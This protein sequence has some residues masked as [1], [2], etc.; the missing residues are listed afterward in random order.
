M[1]ESQQLQKANM[2]LLSKEMSDKDRSIKTQLLLS[3]SKPTSEKLSGER[4]WKNNGFF[5]DVRPDLNLDKVNMP[6]NTLFYINQGFLSTVKN[7]EIAMYVQNFILGQIIVAANQPKNTDEHVCLENEVKLLSCVYDIESGDFKGVRLM[8]AYI[9]LRGDEDEV[10]LS[11][12]YNK[13]KSK[14]LYSYSKQQIPDAF[15]STSFNKHYSE[16]MNE[17]D[18]EDFSKFFYYLPSISD[19]KEAINQWKDNP[20]LNPFDVSYDFIQSFS[21][22]EEVSFQPHLLNSLDKKVR[23]P[24]V[25]ILRELFKHI[26][27]ISNQNLERNI[28]YLNLERNSS[29]MEWTNS[30][31]DS[32]KFKLTY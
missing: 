17:R 15:T 5:K 28:R 27:I 3:S 26:A 14:I 21:P 29:E 24:Q 8:L 20:S 9:V 13:T 12:G 32:S 23:E 1:T 6:E 31:F 22:S 11:Y 2:L 18:S 10:F 7:G 4:V 19:R 30:R 25:K 16:I